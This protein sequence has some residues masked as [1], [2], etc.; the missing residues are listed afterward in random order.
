[1]NGRLLDFRL[2]GAPERYRFTT[3]GEETGGALVVM[4]AW[5]D[6]GAPW[7]GPDHVHH[8][9]EE[10]YEVLAGTLDVRVAGDARKLAAGESLAIPAGTPHTFANHSQAEVHFVSEHRPALRFQELMEAWYAPVAA[11]RLKKANSVRGLMMASM[12]AERFKPE[13]VFANPLFRVAQR[14]LA[15]FGRLAGYDA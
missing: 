6:P 4:E 12:V 13:L 9:Q 11:G 1:M 15:T 7:S 3:S 5:L 8:F 2:V 10:R 14:V